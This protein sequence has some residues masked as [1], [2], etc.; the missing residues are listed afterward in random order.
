MDR[1]A[2][3]NFLEAADSLQIKGLS[4]LNRPPPSQ[5]SLNRFSASEVG[6][7]SRPGASR[8]LSTANEEA[9]VPTEP[10]QHNSEVAAAA[11]EPSCQQAAARDGQEQQQQQQMVRIVKKKRTSGHQ[12]PASPRASKKPKRLESN[13]QNIGQRTTG[14]AEVIFFFIIFIASTGICTRKRSGI[15]A[16][17]ALRF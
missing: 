3:K 11:V 2:L 9:E 1:C 16:V 4:N 17:W 14:A 5:N 13:S 8:K 15:V 12:L 10:R 7:Q 6:S